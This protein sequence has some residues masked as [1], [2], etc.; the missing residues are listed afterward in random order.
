MSIEPRDP[1]VSDEI[2]ARNGERRDTNDENH[3]THSALTAHLQRWGLR[4]FDS[5]AAYFAWQSEQ[6]SQADITTL[7]QL[8]TCKQA[9]EPE[10][11]KKPR[12]MMQRPDRTSFRRYTANAITT[13]SPSAHA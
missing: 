11:R 10:I 13:I 8:V 12:S 9:P 5:D 2:R 1:N 4:E 6:F 3:P 7:H